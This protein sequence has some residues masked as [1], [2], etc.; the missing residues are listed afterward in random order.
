MTSMGLKRQTKLT[1][2][3]VL[4]ALPAALQSEGFGVITEVDIKQTLKDKIGVDIR[5]YQVLGAC[6]PH[7]AHEALA[8]DLDIGF[9]LPCNVAVYEADDG[10]AVVLAVNPA[11]AMA[12]HDSSAILALAAKVRDRLAQ[13]LGKLG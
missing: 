1:Y 9:M 8:S 7:F 4:A 12:N 5:R 2:D 13:A 11:V 6:N 10:H 3:Q